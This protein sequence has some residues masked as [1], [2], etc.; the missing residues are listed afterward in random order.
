MKSKILILFVI[1]VLMINCNKEDKNVIVN[2]IDS[3]TK[4]KIPTIVI[5]G[6]IEGDSIYYKQFSPSIVIKGNMVGTINDYTY[7][8]SLGLDLNR[9]SI[10]D[11]QFRYFMSF[12]QPTNCDTNVID[13][14]MP[15]GEAMCYIKSF[16]SNFEVAIDKLT[17]YPHIYN[18]LDTISKYDNW[19][20]VNKAI[21]F[22]AAGL[23]NGWD[24][25]EIFN[26][27][28]LRIKNI[29]NY[30]YGWIRLN[31]NYSSEIRLFDYVIHK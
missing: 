16:S 3:T 8:D 19:Q 26:F 24:N 29:N 2:Q 14:C 7:N 9:D 11:I 5:A 31:T 6:I 4:V 15:S 20:N 10:I 25:T 12:Y 27:M 17:G 28:G 23:H 1:S 18:S 13:G 22:S 30:K 21:F